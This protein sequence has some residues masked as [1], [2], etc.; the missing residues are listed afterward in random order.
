[1]EGQIGGVKKE[2]IQRRRVKKGKAGSKKRQ[3]WRAAALVGKRRKKS[4]M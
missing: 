4:V 2:E 3:N 1:M